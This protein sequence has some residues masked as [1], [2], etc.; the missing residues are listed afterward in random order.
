VAIR[1]GVPANG[2]F[3]LI[4]CSTMTAMIAWLSY[5]GVERPI[6]EAVARRLKRADTLPVSAVL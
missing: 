4:I 6:R 1:L 3:T 5:R 2:P